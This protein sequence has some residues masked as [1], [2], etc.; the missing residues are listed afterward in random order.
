MK[1]KTF[2]KNSSVILA[3]GILSPYWS[4]T[5]RK[6]DYETPSRM[7]SNWAGNYTYQAGHLHEP[8]SVD[9]VVNLVSKLDKQKALG[10]RHCFNNIA[11][12]PQHQI[13]L[14]NLN[15]VIAVDEAKKT[16]TIEGGVRYG[17]FSESLHEKGYALHNL[18]S[19]PHITVAGA[20]ATATHGSGVR[21]GNLATAVSSVELVTPGGEV[22]KIDRDH[23]DF[24][25]VVVGLG[26]FGIITKVTL[27]I[28][29]TFD[30]E[31]Y[32]FQDLPLSSVKSNFQEIMSAGY[33]VSLFTDWRD[34]KISE[35]WIKRR[36]DDGSDI[37]G[38]DFYGAVA[39]EKNLHPIA[40]LSAESCTE[41]LGVP[42]PWYN[43]LPH[44]K[45]GFT[46]SA[47][48]ELQSEYFVPFDQAVEAI[49]AIEKMNAEISPH[50]M[51][52]E[53]RTIAAD[54]FWLSPCY[55]QN[56]VAIHFTWKQKPKEVMDLLPKIEA[57]LA[58]YG[59]KP[60]WGKLFTIGKEELQSR[61]P[62]RKDF[63]KLV[64][65]YDPEE[66]FINNYLSSHV[67]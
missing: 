20:C 35:V 21:N 47:G 9:D 24:H 13:S 55:Q 34:Q 42:G 30:V 26:A 6:S 65:T 4:C 22:V 10:S 7:R 12:S 39:A 23:P 53:I 54:N 67:M 59:V 33:S 61:Y 36:A 29:E 38:R 37:P 62:R 40:E 52:T 8:T 41:Q 58:T 60:H 2:L 31:Q 63:R 18:A 28:Q 57:I 44:F 19:L 14:K 1:R 49:L 17:D 56:S 64:K 11:D 3:G 5:P 48:A 16:I 32:V 25:A 45:M 43:R 50:L 51:I 46:P 66:K 15:K 27:D